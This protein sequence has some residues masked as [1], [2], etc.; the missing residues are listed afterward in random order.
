ME[1]LVIILVLTLGALLILKSAQAGDC[2]KKNQ[3]G[4]VYIAQMQM[5]SQLSCGKQYYKVG[6]TGDPKTRYPNDKSADNP[7]PIQIVKTFHVSQWKEAESAVKGKLT[8]GTNGGGTEWYM[9]G[10]Q[11]DVNDLFNTV[12]NNVKPYLLGK[13]AVEAE[14]NGRNARRHHHLIKLLSY[15]LDWLNSRHIYHGIAKQTEVHNNIIVCYCS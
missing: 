6:A 12:W 7:F 14:A 13:N 3:E 8:L 2:R 15:L 5:P 9:A 10:S 1:K 4:Y 11:D